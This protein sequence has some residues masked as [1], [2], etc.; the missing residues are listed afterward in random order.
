MLPRESLWEFPLGKAG[1]YPR[2]DGWA[3]CPDRGTEVGKE[4]LDVV[5]D[6]GMCYGSA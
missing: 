4:R 6:T 3:G 2:R 1:F 5:E